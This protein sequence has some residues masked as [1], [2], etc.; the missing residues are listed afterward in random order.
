MDDFDAGLAEGYRKS[1]DMRHWFLV[2]TDAGR[3]GRGLTLAEARKNAHLGKTD[4]G[5]KVFVQLNIQ[6]GFDKIDADR[7]TSIKKTDP[8][9]DLKIGD[10][11]PPTVNEYGASVYYGRMIPIE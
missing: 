2:I 4:R 10:F 11:C 7:L 9:T 8:N 6:T 1:E 3:W 5:R